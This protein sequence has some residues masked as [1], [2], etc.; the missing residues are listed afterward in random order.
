MYVPH[1]GPYV[2][3][4]ARVPLGCLEGVAEGDFE[5]CIDRLAKVDLEIVDDRIANILPAG[6]GL[7]GGRAA[8]LGGVQRIDLHAKMVLP[9]FADLHTHIGERSITRWCTHRAGS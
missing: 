2:L 6:Q 3:T 1:K 4:N 7:Q 5:V 9:T 8:W